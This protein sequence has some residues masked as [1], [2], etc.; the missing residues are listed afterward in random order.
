MKRNIFRSLIGKISLLVIVLESLTFISMGSYY[1][2]RFGREID[3]RIEAQVQWPGILMNRQLLLY[4]SVADQE[5]LSEMVGEELVDALVID[6]NNKVF[7][8]LHS[9]DLGKDAT[10]LPD[11]DPRW[12]DHLVTD[13]PIIRRI[14]RDRHFLISVTPLNAYPDFFVYIKVNTT[15]SEYQKNAIWGLFLLT[16]LGCVVLTSL[17]LIIGLRKMVTHPLSVLEGNA[18]HIARGNLNQEIALARSDELGHLAQS[19]IMM[20]DVIRAKI[21][22]LEEFSHT[23]E[24]KVAERTQEL[25]KTVADLQQEIT[26]RRGM[27]EA[28]GE[29]ERRYRH[30]VENITETLYTTDLQGVL[31]YVSPSI[32]TVSGFIPAELVGRHFTEIAVPE[33]RSLLTQVF[34]KRLC[35]KTGKLE[36]RLLHQTGEYRWIHSSSQ[37]MRSADKVIGIQG[38]LMDIT[39]RKQM[40][41]ALRESEARLQIALGALQAGVWEHNLT[42]RRVHW[43]ERTYRLFDLVPYSVELTIEDVMAFILPEDRN[44]KLPAYQQA[45]A[46]GDIW[47]EEYRITWADGSLHW[48]YAVGEIFRNDKGEAAQILGINFDITERKQMETAVAEERN[49]LQVLINTI[50]EY[51]YVKDTHRRFLL[52]NNACV[53]ALGLS[54]LD[55]LLGRTDNDLFPSE[56]AEQ[57]ST[58][59][60]E[61]LAS[62]KAVIN[63]E[64]ES[65]NRQTGEPIWSLVTKV[66][67]RDLQGKLI[68]LVGFSHDITERKQSEKA[69]QKANNDLKRRNEELLTLNRIAQTVNT[70]IDL[71]ETLDRTAEM[72]TRQFHARGAVIGLFDK[73]R[74]AFITSAHYTINPEERDSLLKRSWPLSQSPPSLGWQILENKRPFVITNAQQ[75]PHCASILDV[76]SPRDILDLMLVPLLIRGEIIGGIILS[77][78]QPDREFGPDE[79]R[80]AET[81]AGQVTGAIENARL[82]HEA[83]LAREHA[84]AANTA[85]S[86]FLANMSHELR[87]PLNGIL[88]YAQLLRRDAAMTGCQKEKLDII[89]RSG[90]HLL[91]LINDILDLAKVES[92]KIEL[93]PEDFELSGLLHHVREIVRVRAERKALVFRLEQ[94]ENLPTRL[95]GDEQRLRQVLL[96][97]LG[98]AV[99]FTDR[100]GVTLRVGGRR[101]TDSSADRETASCLPPT[102]HLTFEVEDT[103]I[104]IA[105]DKIEAIF[106]PFQQVGDTMYQAQGTGLGLSISRKLIRLMG[107]ELF[108]E[109]TPGQG[110]TFRFALSLPE[111]AVDASSVT[112]TRRRIVGVHGDAPTLLIVD[113]NREGRGVLI[114]LLRPLGFELLEAG[115]GDEALKKVKANRPNAVIT[116]IMMPGMDGLELIRQIRQS[117]EFGETIIIATSAR[118]YEEDQQ[119][120]VAAGSHAFL[121]K[122]IQVGQLFGL[123]QKY[124]HVE[125]VYSTDEP[126]TPRIDTSTIPEKLPA[127][128][129]IE[130]LLNASK[131]GDIQAF[132]GLLSMLEKADPDLHTFVTILDHL[133]QRFQL[134]EMRNFLE[135]C[136][137]YRRKDIQQLDDHSQLATLSPESLDHF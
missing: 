79:I 10:E 33:D 8:A 107:G 66:P 38:M 103:G 126:A 105:P 57:Y 32:Q 87:T 119:R 69:I 65:L 47:K 49:L 45:V 27:E 68:G 43:D 34:T 97:L 124:L 74:T 95:Y 104:G 110:S 137:Q 70:T 42:T 123:L 102:A 9:E 85:K 64:E 108:V 53:R 41:E 89:E 48:I 76:L 56:L 82:F 13:R 23:L 60:V 117:S 62:G 129:S 59:E 92:G 98:N 99:K 128:E 122:P 114:D 11:M 28:L 130:T 118:V 134:L 19:F 96:N 93:S 63:Q 16:S 111:A 51:I 78:D 21:R 12:F 112:G 37:P 73:Q 83:Q 2:H 39:E 131:I 84:E 18:D 90:N 25:N 29:N 26:T 77:S 121:P 31:T 71:Q 113:D 44:V 94:A 52:A 75:N 36:W 58:S 109:S 100:G 1:S 132:R 35:G 22:Q 101:M 81:I 24:R 55:E 6:S 54:T 3:R 136:Q 7:Y 116:D 15:H 72:M 106:E 115:D 127:P 86:A 5:I 17:I 20:R 40:E 4:E 50:P 67:L 80:L 133:A 14:E 125:W 46:T 30:L 91:S 135:S 61:L 88:G 120:C